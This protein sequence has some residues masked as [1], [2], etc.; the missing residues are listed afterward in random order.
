MLKIFKRFLKRKNSIY[1]PLVPNNIDLRNRLPHK[2]IEKL[3]V[4]NVGVGSGDSGLARQLPYFD[5][6]LLHHIDVHQP[7]LDAAR[8]RT[9]ATDNIKFILADI[10]NFD[11]SLY[12]Y[13]LMFDILEHLPKADS[14]AVMD[15]IKCHQVIF[16]PLEKEFRP[17]VFGAKSQDHLSLWTE[18]DFIHLGYKTEVLKYF[19]KEGQNI[20]DALW[21]VK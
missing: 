19:H 6:F 8:L 16:I 5:F 11:T 4:L 15:K 1:Y 20:F 17:N 9:W 21:A 14:L 12:N 2:G 13:V 3:K 7:Y 10:R 18:R